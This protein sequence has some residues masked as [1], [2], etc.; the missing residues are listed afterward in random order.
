MPEIYYTHAMWKVKEGKEEEFVRAW[1]ALGYV[2]TA[3][4]NASKHGTLIQSVT[5]P[6]LFYSFGPWESLEAISAMRSDPQAQ[7]AI[8]AVVDLCEQATPGNYRVVRQIDTE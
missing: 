4:P 5:D 2:F 8:R 6:T 3:L 7:L 1:E